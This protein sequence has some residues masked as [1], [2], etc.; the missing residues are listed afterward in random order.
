MEFAISTPLVGSLW[1]MPSDP[2]VA[3]MASASG[4]L[5][6][7]FND[8][9]SGIALSDPTTGIDRAHY[10][11]V[12]SSY[13]YVA[14]YQQTGGGC[15]TGSTCWRI[16]KRDKGNATT[17]TTFGDGGRSS[18]SITVTGYGFGVAPGGSQ[19]NCAGAVDTGCVRFTVG[20]NATIIDADLT[21]WANTS[22]AFAINANL[23]SDGGASALE[24]LAAAQAD[25]SKI[26]FF[27]YPRITGFTAAQSD[28]DIQTATITIS[29]DHFGTS[30][31]STDI[32]F[33]GTTA[34]T[35]GTWAT[36]TITGVAIPDSGTD[37][38]TITV[39]RVSDSKASNPST[40]FYIYPD[41][42]SL[43]VPSG[44]PADSAREFASGDLDGLIMLNGTHFGSATGTVTILTATSTYHVIVEGSCT[45]AGHAVTSAC[46]EVS[47]NISDTIN[48][49]NVV[50]MRDA[51]SKQS[52]FA[53]FRVLPRIVSA[54]PTSP[55]IGQVTQIVGNHFCQAASCP[56]GS[57]RDSATSSVTFATATST[58]S[59]FENLTGGAGACDGSGAS[60][61]DGEVCVRVPSGTPTG[62]QP[63]VVKSDTYDS[64]SFNVTV[65]GGATL[66]TTVRA[67]STTVSQNQ[68]GLLVNV[69]VHNSGS[70]AAN[71]PS[72]SAGA[73]LNFTVD[74]DFTVT[75][76]DSVTSVAGGATSTLAFDVSVAGGATTG[77]STIDASVTSTDANSGADISKPTADTT[78]SWTVQTAPNLTLTVIATPTTVQQGDQDVL[79]TL[80]VQNAAN[81]ATANISS[82]DIF[83]TNDSDFTETRTDSVTSIASG[84]TQNLTFDV[85]VSWTAATVSNTIDGSVTSTD[86]NTGNIIS[87][88]NADTTDSWTVAQGPITVMRTVSYTVTQISQITST[89][90][91]TAPFKFFLAETSP[92]I[93]S[94]YVEVT[95]VAIG[96]GTTPTLQIRLNAQTAKTFDLPNITTAQPFTVVYDLPVSTISCTT[97]VPDQNAVCTNGTTDNELYLTFGGG[98][99]KAS[100]VRA[101]FYAT[102]HYAP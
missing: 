62:S 40:T 83:F 23:A 6:S 45:A 32:N 97:P 13:I 55:T 64:N 91:T 85:D 15:A 21:S 73:D 53:G 90:V 48:T 56:T 59:D 12:D 69:D 25:S 79:V 37:S 30:G 38:G 29:G 27:I 1:A 71:I 82:A 88:P 24:T 63:I 33:N 26:T 43:A 35:V 93:R 60:W 39:T 46:V 49:G 8:G 14:G 47:L 19:D 22:L 36:S 102:Y 57:Q 78:D 7:A 11:T 76:T 61:V 87:D 2:T 31:T 17:T 34:E 18:D 66:T 95:G 80:Q 10:I 9:G 99:S 96:T 54:T 52:I 20:G 81:A 68:T 5:E 72:G 98:F 41:I 70:A 94:G 3:L 4:A 101:R 50:L 84:A 100:L 67:T 44:F 28:G 16:E 86:A 77:V 51:D 74:G 42:V 58:V 75:R 89:S 92:T 65:G